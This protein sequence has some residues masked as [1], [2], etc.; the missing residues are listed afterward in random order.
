[1]TCLYTHGPEGCDVFGLLVRRAVFGID[2]VSGGRGTEFN[3]SAEAYSD[4]VSDFGDSRGPDKVQYSL[5]SYEPIS[6]FQSLISASIVTLIKYR[7]RPSLNQRWF[8]SRYTA[9]GYTAAIHMASE[10]SR[11]VSKYPEEYRAIIICG[12]AGGL[13]W[14]ARSSG[15]FPLAALNGA[16]QKS[17]IPEDWPSP[18]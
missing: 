7:P 1:M 13:V 14:L 12:G 18:R 11:R 17:Q 3:Q 8:S 9:H 4:L 15:L 2:E 5:S 16:V 10:E 6:P